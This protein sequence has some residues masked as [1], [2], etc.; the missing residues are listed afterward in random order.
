MK[1]HLLVW[2]SSLGAAYEAA[3]LASRAGAQILE[4]FPFVSKGHLFLQISPEFGIG[5]FLAS[6]RLSP[7][8]ME[9]FSALSEQV[10][11]AYLSL[12]NPPLGEDL[13]IAEFTFLGDSLRIASQAE[14]F[15]LQLLDIRFMRDTTGHS[16]FMATGSSEKCTAFI[17]QLL[18]SSGKIRQ[19]KNPS[20]GLREFF[21]RPQNA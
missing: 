15:G 21:P 4:L 7:D 9:V 6:L 5:Q 13:L 2:F 3:D 20:E 17:H 12:S 16:Y 11:N 1:K 10:L 14:K 19:I 18:P 8:N